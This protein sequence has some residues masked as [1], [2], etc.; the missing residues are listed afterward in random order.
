MKKLFK[1]ETLFPKRVKKFDN[2]R[3]SSSVVDPFLDEKV[4]VK[5]S[6]KLDPPTFITDPYSVSTPRVRERPESGAREFT[7][8][9]KDL[10]RRSIVIAVEFPVQH[11]SLEFVAFSKI[12]Q[13]PIYRYIGPLPFQL[14]IPYKEL[15]ST[16]GPSVTEDAFDQYLNYLLPEQDPVPR[17]SSKR[18]G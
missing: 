2:F 4:A 1:W 7:P 10:L 13:C 15:F 5:V 12:D 16:G 18:C 3:T 17:V 14:D 11:K 8:R 9:Y 6:E